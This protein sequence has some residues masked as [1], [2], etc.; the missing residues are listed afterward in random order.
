MDDPTYTDVEVPTKKKNNED[1]RPD[2]SNVEVPTKQYSLD[3]LGCTANGA[4]GCR[5]EW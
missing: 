1:G 5:A 3:M 4:S 2:I